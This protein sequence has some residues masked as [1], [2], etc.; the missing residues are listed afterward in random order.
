MEEI[1]SINEQEKWMEET[2]SNIR[3]CSVCGEYEHNVSRFPKNAEVSVLKWDLKCYNCGKDTPVIWTKDIETNGHRF[4]IEPYSFEDLKR[5]LSQ[6]YPF[7]KMVS[8]KTQEVKEF[9]N[10]CIHCDAYQGDWYIKEDLMEIYASESECILD[11]ENV[12]INLTEKERFEHAYRILNKKLM[13]RTINKETKEKLLMCND[14]W[15][16]R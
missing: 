8:K 14:C 7:F 13:N 2:Y 6:K 9:G 5:T 10:T 16:K 11:T 12:Q 3:K 4:S 1:M 15:K